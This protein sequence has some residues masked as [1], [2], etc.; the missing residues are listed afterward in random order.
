MTGGCPANIGDG[1]IRGVLSSVDCQTRDFAESGYAALTGA[2]SPFQA[3]LTAM[4]TI[5]I[6]VVGYRMLFAAGGARLS[7]AGGIALKVGVILAL[8]TSWSTFETLVFDV[9]AKAPVDTAALLGEPLRGQGSTLAGDPVGGLQVAYDQLS[10]SARAFGAQAGPVAKS[11]TSSAA[12]AAEALSGAAGALFITSAGLI[13]MAMIVVAVLSA[14]GP[15]FIVLFLFQETRGLFVGW[16]RALIAAA[17]ALFGAWMLTVMMLAVL[18]PWLIALAQQRRDLALDETTALS[19][20]GVVFVFAISQIGL[21]V[22][23]CAVA[24]SLR[25]RTRQIVDRQAETPPP[26][27]ADRAEEISRAQRLALAL[28]TLNTVASHRQTVAATM[29]EA[30]RPGGFR[31]VESAEPRLGEAL[32]RVAFRDRRAPA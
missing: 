19:A 17:L 32:R 2:G 7:D 12:A 8:V 4:L 25:L 26:P 10:L 11:Y 9:A 14:V 22:S 15:I 29:A 6:A 5:Y 3:A 16:L 21:L 23:L 20:S 24:M 30:S 13:A 28:H 31:A 18:E 1:L 27:A